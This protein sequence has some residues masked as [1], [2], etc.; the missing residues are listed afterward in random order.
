M[1]RSASNGRPIVLVCEITAQNDDFGRLGRPEDRQK[2]V[3]K[4]RELMTIPDWTAHVRSSSIS[5]FLTPRPDDDARISAA[6][7]SQWFRSRGAG[8]YFMHVD[9]AASNLRQLVLHA[10][11]EA[12]MQ[13]AHEFL[14]VRMQRDQTTMQLQALMRERWRQVEPWLKHGTIVRPGQDDIHSALDLPG[15]PVS[16]MPMPFW[17]A[18]AA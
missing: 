1:D 12:T 9:M 14:P 3:A 5:L 10:E 13:M 4:L 16:L 17:S 7:F 6:F 8:G 11:R 18:V 2:V 15:E